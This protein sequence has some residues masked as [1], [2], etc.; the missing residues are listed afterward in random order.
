MNKAIFE[1]AGKALT[2]YF[3]TKGAYLYV[4]PD[5]TLSTM[6]DEYV[7]LMNHDRSLGKYEIATGEIIMEDE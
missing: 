5:I 7:Y 4:G 3:A 6:D 1:K 2:E